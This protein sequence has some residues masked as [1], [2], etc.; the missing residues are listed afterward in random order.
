MSLCWP[1]GRVSHSSS[2]GLLRLPPIWFP[3]PPRS[4]SAA[5]AAGDDPASPTPLRAPRV[6][7]DTCSLVKEV[8]DLTHQTK[9]RP[10]KRPRK[11]PGG[12][13]VPCVEKSEEREA[14]EKPVYVGF[15]VPVERT[16]AWTGG[17]G[18]G[19][20]RLVGR[21]AGQIP[22]GATTSDADRKAE[23]E[24]T[25][26]RG[27]PN[28]MRGRLISS[29]TGPRGRRLPCLRELCPPATSPSGGAPGLDTLAESRQVV[30]AIALLRYVAKDRA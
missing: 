4:A 9:N 29:V 8:V 25:S 2:L 28:P 17:H 19:R 1:C 6:T 16:A 13:H 26:E 20:A 14:T 23:P 12:G 5:A 18:V 22:I 7:V 11:D 21:Q 15:F 24:P 27:D 10:I 30:A 3:I